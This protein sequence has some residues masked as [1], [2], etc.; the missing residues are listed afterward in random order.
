MVDSG[1]KVSSDGGIWVNPRAM[2]E[3]IFAGGEIPETEAFRRYYGKSVNPAVI[4]SV[5]RMADY[6]FM[7]DLTDLEYETVRLDGH[8]GAVL[9]KRFRRLLTSQVDV[10]AATGEGLDPARAE[11][12]ADEV[13]QNIASISNFRRSLLR[14]T[15]GHFHGRASLEKE[16]D[17]HPKPV[18]GLRW[19]IRSLNW[20]HPRRLSFGPERELRVRDDLFW[21]GGF[22]GLSGYGGNGFTPVGYDL[23]EIPFKWITFTP[24]MFNDYPEREGIGAHCLYWAYFKRFDWRERL[25][26]TEVFGK[27]WRI[28]RVDPQF[29]NKVQPKMLDAAQTSVNRL[30]ANNSAVLPLGTLLQVEQPQAHAGEIH[31]DGIL[32]ANDEMSKIVL[33]QT[34]S[35]DA[36]PG[37][38]GTSADENAADSE[39]LII[40][41]DAIN[42]G[43]IL[44]QQFSRDL[45]VVNHGEEEAA[46]TPIISLKVEAPPNREK[47]IKNVTSFLSLGLPMKTA[48]I[49]EA[50]GYERPAPDDEQYTLP[51]TVTPIG[52]A[53]GLPQGPE[54]PAAP[55][56]PPTPPAPPAPPEPTSSTEPPEAGTPGT[57]PTAQASRISDVTCFAKQPSTVNG[58][59]EPLV[60]RGVSESARETRRWA[61]AIASSVEGAET[62]TAI[63]DAM[64]RAAEGIDLSPFARAVER[65]LVQGIMLG[66]LDSLWERENDEELKAEA[67]SRVFAER[68]LMRGRPVPCMFA[69]PARAFADQPFDKAVRAFRS[70][71]VLP[72]D[73]FEQLSAAAKRRSFTIARLANQELL[74]AAHA[75]LTRQIELG[76]DSLIS[77]AGPDLRDFRAFVSKRLES[78]GWTPANPSHVETIFRTNVMSAYGVGRRKEMTQP[79]VLRTR[80]IW[81]WRSVRDDRSRE[82]HTRPNGVAMPADDAVWNRVFAPAGFNCRCR[83]VSRSV[84]WAEARDLR[85]GPVSAFADLPDPGFDSSGA[86]ELMG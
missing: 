80:P 78:A 55:P 69:D 38:L 83:I 67:F 74:T 48:E 51:A 65:R 2:Q 37:G 14:L 45:M 34:R 42:L 22:G 72:K 58:S 9:G 62:P 29:S 21:A 84:R 24:Q 30:G 13:R 71:E 15:W 43:E 40:Q 82:S 16:W 76:R 53:S 75:E 23:R 68:V 77:G 7:R 39:Q 54:T 20:I 6:G 11:K 26:L 56:T 41:A 60:D 19:T 57:P 52:G 81:Q 32:D 25:I 31:R 64:N 8:L 4:E 85:T 79:D 61:D 36:K 27:P 59:P 66:A 17:Y 3:E 47:S 63:Y 73:L 44:T 33:G 35:T 12:R 70:R 28:I 18:S 49:Y 50:S 86:S 46:Y 1:I 10:K 5:I